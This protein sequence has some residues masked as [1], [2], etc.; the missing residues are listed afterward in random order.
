M[1]RNKKRGFCL[2]AGICGVVV[3]VCGVANLFKEPQTTT[4]VQ[5]EDG[6]VV[7]AEELKDVYMIGEQ[8]RLTEGLIMHNGQLYPTQA[9]YL[10][11]PN[12]EIYQSS[13]YTLDAL[14][15]YTVMYAATT[16]NGTITA[17][18]EFLVCQNAYSGT[19]ISY[20]YR[21]QLNMNESAVSGLGVT[22]GEGGKFTLNHAVDISEYTANDALFTIY[23]YNRT[24]LMGQS[25]KTH[26]TRKVYVRIT[27]C[28]DPSIYLDFAFSWG[29][30]DA[31]IDPN[32]TCVYVRAG[33][34]NQ[35]LMGLVPASTPHSLMQ[36][37]WYKGSFYR[38][39]SMVEY[40]TQSRSRTAEH[41][42]ADNAGFSMYYDY[43]TKEIYFEDFGGRIFV[44][45]LDAPEIYN[46]NVFR[47]FTTGEVYFSMWGDQYETTTMNV[48]IAK[49]GDYVGEDFENLD[50]VYD[51]QAPTVELDS[52]WTENQMIYAA[53]GDAF[54]IPTPTCRDLY[55]T[56]EVV[57]RVY[58]NY[59]APT[60]KQIPFSAE[61]TFIPQEIGLYTVEYSVM[62]VYGNV[63][64]E[65]FSLNVLG[66]EGDQ[67]VSLQTEE[68]DE[69]LAG[70]TCELPE[71]TLTGVNGEEYVKIFAVYEGEKIEIDSEN[72]CFF[73]DEIGEYEILYIYGDKYHTYTYSYA[74]TAKAS[75]NVHIAVPLLPTYFI[76]GMPYTLEGNTV[77][78]Y[79]GEKAIDVVSSVLMKE[80]D[81]EFK[82][83]TNYEKVTVTAQNTVQFRYVYDDKYVDSGKIPVIDVNAAG[84]LNLKEYF[85]GDFNKQSTASYMQYTSN[86][87]LGANKL[88]FINV[89]G[90]STFAL[91]FSIL[92]AESQFDSVSIV[93]R[94]YENRDE[95]VVITYGKDGSNGYFQLN[96]G[97]KN[98]TGKPFTDFT[99]NLGYNPTLGA[100]TTN[101]DLIIQHGQTIGFER[102]LLS[103]EFNEIV[104]DAGICISKVNNQGF[105]S[106]VFK[107]RVKA[108]VAF[109]EIYGEYKIGAMVAVY[110]ATVTDVISPYLRENFSFY[111]VAPSGK[112]VVSVDN[113]KMENGCPINRAYS[114][115]IEEYGTYYI[116]YSYKDFNGNDTTINL[117][118]IIAEETPPTLKIEGLE[119]GDVQ[120]AKVNTKVVVAKYTVSDNQT[121]SNE[122]NSRVVVCSPKGE[123]IVLNETLAF[124]ATLCGDYKV[125]YYCFD[126]VGN[127]TLSY[128]YIRVK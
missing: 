25:G 122:L 65:T 54:V 128:Y 105:T 70:A 80:D 87:T 38:G 62:D 126:N 119:E 107:D 10:S 3:S 124:D 95:K 121:P 19:K 90:L 32:D 82:E 47:G 85:F 102:T 17:E 76:K 118:I 22:I 35:T 98:P 63:G 99:F 37:I 75:D 88:D 31:K 43:Q 67:A 4:R 94:N 78:L 56:A 27:D 44:N 106:N 52:I 20:E 7:L 108:T 64:I 74:L 83:V 40:G 100:F 127:Y 93:L 116:T 77:R 55:N 72:R 15:K 125:C 36:S 96:D 48:E 69:V 16:Q 92:E 101:T 18:R 79:N 2:L 114:F 58:K 104:G 5:A 6:E 59:G 111:A 103:I 53:K 61:N 1:T 66:I 8:L 123:L 110:P 115:K 12:G 21:E 39:N 71:Y 24:S 68:L 49:I 41:R 113:V 9:A 91:E 51:V 11:Y 45:D 42:N 13:N 26:E 73:V 50:L 97:L 112:T 23:P 33:G 89:I 14:G 81:G 29:Q 34:S 117:P 57:A 86:V 60:Q 120:K 109:D 84:A 28:Y 46:D 30:L